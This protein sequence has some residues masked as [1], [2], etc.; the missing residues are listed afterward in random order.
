[1]WDVRAKGFLDRPS[2]NS[3]NI[4]IPQQE[5]FHNSSL[6]Y[7][8]RIRITLFVIRFGLGQQ[9]RRIVQQPFDDICGACRVDV[10]QDLFQ[11]IFADVPGRVVVALQNLYQ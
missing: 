5:V 8:A 3:C 9:V 11:V 2:D 4:E 7:P 1:M 6:D 10:A